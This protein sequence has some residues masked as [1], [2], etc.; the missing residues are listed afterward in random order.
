MCAAKELIRSS[1]NEECA[2][3]VLIT[4]DPNELIKV[5]LIRMRNTGASERVSWSLVEVPLRL[6]NDEIEEKPD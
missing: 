1:S 3:K 4:P 2:L 6:R 5:Q